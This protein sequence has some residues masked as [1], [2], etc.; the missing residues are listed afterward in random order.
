[1]IQNYS[2]K[3][4]S[5]FDKKWPTHNQFLAGKQT[6]GDHFIQRN[7]VEFAG[8]HLIVDLWGAHHL[9]DLEVMEKAMRS[10]VDVTSATLLHLHLHHFTPNFG[11]SGVAVLAESHIS[12]HTWPER[13]Y[14]AFDIFMC[15]DTKPE[16]AIAVLKA[17]FQPDETVVNECLRGVKPKKGNSSY[18]IL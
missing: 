13:M 17:T 10:C 1:M 18:E 6:A 9:D 4:N 11:I 8:I 2:L 15:G 16:L 5:V 12:V 14:A 3:N 7:G